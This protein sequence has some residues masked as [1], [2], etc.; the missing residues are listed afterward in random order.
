MARTFAFP[1]LDRVVHGEG[2]LAAL[3]R[4]VD[5]LGGRRVLVATGR[6]LAHETPVIDGI[7][8]A[9]G[10]RCA[11]VYDGMR[12]HAPAS[13]VAGCIDRIDALDVDVLVGVGGSSPIDA[14]KVAALRVAEARDPGGTAQAVA[15]VAVPTTLSAGELTPGAG[16]TGEVPGVKSYV[17]DPR[18]MPRVIVYDP[19][20]TRYTPALLWA[21]TGVKSLDHAC[22][23]LWS[24]S[25]HPVTG[26][27]AEASLTALARALP[28]SVADPDDLEA[29]ADCQVAAWMS[30]A[31]IVNTGVYL[32]HAMGHQIGARWDVTHG[33]TS[34]ITLP[35]VMRFIA[36]DADPRVLAAEA[37]VARALG[38][39]V[40]GRPPVTV[41]ADGADALAAL[42]GSLGVPTRLSEVGA[43]RADIP[44][45]A[46]ATAG[47]MVAF[48]HP[49]PAH[50]DLVALLE[51]M[52]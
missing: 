3:P 13:A 42:I 25:T 49:A 44:A 19:D 15:L 8:A 43:D 10:D 24:P 4:E 26:A 11:G 36:R 52:W 27:L 1:A 20:A 16:I 7:V 46:E 32:S 12:Q 51:S 21:S 23:M 6:T 34:C 35:A 38:V 14:A 17:S 5:R 9:L 28:A 30:M 50:D 29:R 22:E 2:A 37:R 48:G 47:A 18:M 39:P 45:V 31:A 40:Y 41:A 33:V